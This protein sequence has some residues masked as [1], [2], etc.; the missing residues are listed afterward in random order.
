MAVDELS[1]VELSVSCFEPHLISIALFCSSSLAPLVERQFR[2]SINR[3][4]LP[5][6]GIS[7]FAVERP[8]ENCP[9]FKNGGCQAGGGALVVAV[10]RVLVAHVGILHLQCL[11]HG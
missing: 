8:A 6:L 9:V 1:S 7:T 4:A 10:S 11:A 3:S 5:I 2:L